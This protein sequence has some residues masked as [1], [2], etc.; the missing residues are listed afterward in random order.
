[1]RVLSSDDGMNGGT[2]SMWVERTMSGRGWPG[3]VAYRLKRFV[4]TGILRASNPRRPRSAKTNSPT[5]GSW[6]VLLL[7]FRGTRLNEGEHE[8][9]V[10]EVEDVR[11][12]LD[13]LDHEFHLPIIFAGFSFR[14]AL[15]L[16]APC[17]DS[18]VTAAIG[19]GLPVTPFDER[20]YD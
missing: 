2:V 4:S 12:A 16:Q 13:W 19:L 14:A 11:V 5:V 10:G 20:S 1:M 3:Q 18:R 7:S 6:P 8:H 9:G 17:A 15:R